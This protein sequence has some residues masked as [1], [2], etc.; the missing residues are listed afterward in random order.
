[1]KSI[2]AIIVLFTFFNVFQNE[3]DKVTIH[4]KN[5]EEINEQLW[6][7]FKKSLENRD[8]KTFNDLH[9]DNVIRVNKY[10]IRIGKDYKNSVKSS[11]QKPSTNKRTFDL[12][13]EQ[14][15]YEG[16]TGYE[17][18]YYKITTFKEGKAPQSIY[19]R[20]H[21]V[22]QKKNSKWLIHQDWD[23]DEINGVKISKEDF[24]KK[25]SLNLD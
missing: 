14:R 3:S 18:G 17:V 7:P 12:W 15:F 5:I 1:M 6:K 19:R 9:T 21:V 24:D 13:F 4:N 20:F 23:T 16:N 22:L 11:Y 2:Y 10:G 25:I 8:W